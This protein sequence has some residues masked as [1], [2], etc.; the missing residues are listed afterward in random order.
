MDRVDGDVTRLLRELAGGRADAESRLLSLVY[1][2]LKQ[3]ARRYLRLERPGHTMSVTDL[4]HETYLKMGNGDAACQDRTH[5]FRLA[6]LAM[7]R[8]LVDHARAHRTKKRGEGEFHFTF[9]DAL[10][11]AAE[12]CDDFLEID[13]ALEKLGVIDAR[14]ARVVELRFFGGLTIQEIAETIGLDARTIKRDWRFAQAWLRRELSSNRGKL[15][16]PSDG[17][18]SI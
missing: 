16:R 7:R 15:C 17:A 13:E 10:F 1:P 9:D 5:F 18:K 8:I 6:A 11:L 3:I 4:V 2:E 14:K 12:R